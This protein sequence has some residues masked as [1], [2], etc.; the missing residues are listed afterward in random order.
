VGT[1]HVL[2]GIVVMVIGF[3]LS[4]IAS[5]GSAVALMIFA[6]VTLATCACTEDGGQ[7]MGARP[8]AGGDRGARS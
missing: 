6:F 5:I 8:R 1:P 7:G 3:D 2:G 4:A